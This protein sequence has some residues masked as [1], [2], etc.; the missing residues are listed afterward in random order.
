MRP[1]NIDFCCKLVGDIFGPPCNYSVGDREEG[2]DLA[3]VMTLDGGEFCDTHCNEE[4]ALCWKHFFDL[5]WQA[6]NDTADVRLFNVEE[7]HE[8]C[9]VQIWRNT[10]TGEQSI[11]WWPA[12]EDW[13]EELANDR[14]GSDENESETRP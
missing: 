7:I 9:V 3:E 10:V 12:E 14:D 1:L 6:A 13:K 2:H 4:Y 5:M 8:N 11:G